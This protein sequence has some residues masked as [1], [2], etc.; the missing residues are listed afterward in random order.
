MIRGLTI[1]RGHADMEEGTSLSTGRGRRAAVALPI[2]ASLF[3]L[4]TPRAT[5]AAC[6]KAIAWTDHTPQQGAKG[7]R[8]FWVN[9]SLHANGL[10]GSPA[11]FAAEVLWVG[12]DNKQ[13]DDWWVEVGVT[14][15]WKNLNQYVYYTAQG[16]NGG[17]TYTEAKF[18]TL[19]V[20]GTGTYFTA[21]LSTTGIYRAEIRPGGGTTESIAWGGH[22]GDT[23]NYSGG[24]ESWCSDNKINWTYVSLNQF[25][26]K[27]DS[28][29]Q[30]INNGSIQPPSGGGTLAWCFQ[31]QT[32]RYSLNPTNASH[33]S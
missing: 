6:T 26:R 11:R 12:T 20:V 4:A 7:A 9:E 19:P 21:Y 18:A 28:T 10:G 27:S 2:L 8:M 3:V 25:L 22:N 30:T 5:L 14:H 15:G 23:V 16:T 24:Y 1:R 29:W 32:F 17:A 13:S 31:P 33:C